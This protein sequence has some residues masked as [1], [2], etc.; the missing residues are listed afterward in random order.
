MLDF[1]GAVIGFLSGFSLIVFGISAPIAV[2]LFLL[3]G[4]EVNV[5][6]SVVLVSDAILSIVA[7]YFYGA[8]GKLNLL[9][10]LSM[11][12]GFLGVFLGVYVSTIVPKDLTILA[13]GLFEVFSGIYIFMGKTYKVKGV[14]GDSISLSR[15]PL[16]SSIGFLAGFFKG[17]LGMGWGPVS[18][19]LLLLIGLE[20]Y[21][22][23]GSSL[24]PRI[25]VSLS[26]GLSY[27]FLGYSDLQL[28][29][30]FLVGGFT[31][32]FTAIRFVKNI[33]SRNHKRLIGLVVLAI[34]VIVII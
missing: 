19:S 13:I 9:I 24:L 14:N 15:V 22:V 33:D 8:K 7:S 10:A 31:G 28:L 12:S 26:G 6:K 21:T 23:I 4:L 18:M 20:P 17:Y 25:F 3:L 32:L 5:V 2:A 34:G 1:W 29:F 30:S 27:M 16:V 11:M